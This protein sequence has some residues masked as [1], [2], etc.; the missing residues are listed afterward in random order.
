MVMDAGSVLLAVGTVITGV[1]G[2][3]TAYNTSRLNALQTVV[4]T[5]QAENARLVKRVEEQDKVI[6]ELRCENEELRAQ[7]N[8]KQRRAW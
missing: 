7:L 2:A 5:L 8:G 4:T 6:D 3:V 1:V